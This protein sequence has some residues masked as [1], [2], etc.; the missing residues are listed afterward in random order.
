MIFKHLSKTAAMSITIVFIC[1]YLL[2]L[3]IGILLHKTPMALGLLNGLTASVFLMLW[4]T[5]QLDM[6]MPVSILVAELL[7][8]ICAVYAVFFNPASQFFRVVHYL[9]YSAHLLI[10][11]AFL[12]F[13]CTF[14]MNRMF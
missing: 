6:D 7:V 12:I 10:I 5:K 9:V 1:I 13:L 4:A 8:V 2:V 11:V 3:L 14:K